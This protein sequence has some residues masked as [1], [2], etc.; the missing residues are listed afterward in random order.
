MPREHIPADVAR[1]IRKEARNRCGYCLSPQQ[2]VMA[3]LEVEHI[4][5]VARGGTNDVSNLWLCCP[6][7]N[8]YK[9][10]RLSAADPETGQD[11]PLFNP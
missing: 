8:R 3:R 6:L 7:C 11:A 2:L 5:P 9:S 4:I 1:R 10:D